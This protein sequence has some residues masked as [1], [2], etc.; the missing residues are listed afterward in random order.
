[1]FGWHIRRSAALRASFA[2]LLA[3][4]L[5]QTASRGSLQDEPGTLTEEMVANLAA[6]R[7]II[8]VVKD[9][10]LIA[11]IE[12]PIEAETRPPTPVVLSSERA[13]IILGADQ[14]S[15]PSSK[16]EIA[17]LD[18]ELPH[19]RSHLLP[20]D[21]HLQA[22]QGGGE[23]TDVEAVGQGL[24]ER[25]N[26]VAQ[27]LHA[28]VNLSAN[29]PLTELIVVGYLPGYGPDIWQLSYQI[30]QEEQE[31]DYWTTRV[32]RPSYLQFWPPEKG[33]PRTLLEF[34]YPS[35]HAPTP[36]LELL[37]QKDPRVEQILSSDPKMA[38]VADR[39]LQGESNK[40]LAADATQFL[41]AILSVIAPP[42]AR[43]TMCS[44]REEAGLEWILAPPPE[45]PA[46]KSHSERPPG[47][48]SLMG[49]PK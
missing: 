32:L 36:L 21:P 33:Q 18:T 13:G 6:G 11:T 42:N 2:A 22:E 44:I 23:A 47:A 48:P 3:V 39:F 10:I 34:S 38:E 37:R 29:E 1:M 41:R 9:A 19:L 14:W 43:E 16:Q 35:D 30:E 15:S 31:L 7:V 26:D 5:A 45:S 40:V 28:K 49:A 4:I 24:L 20:S 46:P 8:A 17:Q 27:N 25:L 12:N